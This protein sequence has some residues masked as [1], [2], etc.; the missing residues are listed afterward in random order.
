MLSQR[1]V[2]QGKTIIQSTQKGLLSDFHLFLSLSMSNICKICD[3]L[4][5]LICDM[6][7]FVEVTIMK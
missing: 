5:V 6:E 4:H 7:T 3:V 2:E 1:C